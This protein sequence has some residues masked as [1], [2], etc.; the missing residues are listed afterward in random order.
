MGRNAVDAS[1]YAAPTQTKSSPCSSL[2]MTGRAVATPENSNAE[3]NIAR[4]S[5]RKIIQNLYPFF[6]AGG[7]F[8]SGTFDFDALA[9]TR[10]EGLSSLVDEE[11]GD[12]VG[13]ERGEN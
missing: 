4:H 12:I 3:R 9:S 13:S 10:S 8:V 1:A 5:E 2:M 11:D 6:A 7:G